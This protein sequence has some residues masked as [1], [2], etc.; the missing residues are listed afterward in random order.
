[1]HFLDK[2]VDTNYENNQW[3]S[4]YPNLRRLNYVAEDIHG[5]NYHLTN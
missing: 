3:N 4:E 2:A 1:M 5:L